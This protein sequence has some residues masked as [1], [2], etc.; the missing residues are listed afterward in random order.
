VHAYNAAIN[1][2]ATAAPFF[3]SSFSISHEIWFRKQDS[4]FRY[5]IFLRPATRIARRA[6]R[7]PPVQNDEETA[8]YASTRHASGRNRREIVGLSLARSIFPLRDRR[9]SGK[10]LI[11]IA[12]VSYYVNGVSIFRYDLSNFQI[13]ATETPQEV[14]LGKDTFFRRIKQP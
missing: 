14:F 13:D 2:A 3:F 10:Q 4:L 7:N 8:R 1:S 12:K 11:D 6:P 9:I 5:W